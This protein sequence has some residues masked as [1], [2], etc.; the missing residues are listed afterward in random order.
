MLGDE[1]ALQGLLKRFIYCYFLNYVCE[2]MP[3]GHACVSP[4]GRKTLEDLVR[5]PGTRVTCDCELP[6][7]GV[8]A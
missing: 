6:S 7:M 8:R 2:C 1:L 3:V 5:S 4:V